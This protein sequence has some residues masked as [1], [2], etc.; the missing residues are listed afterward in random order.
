MYGMATPWLRWCY[1]VCILIKGAD[2]LLETIG[3]VMFFLV[4]QATLTGWILHITAREVAADPDDWAANVLRHAF[5]QMSGGSKFFAGAYLL[6]HGLLK[7]ALV[8]AVFRQ[9]QW[10]FFAAV[11]VLVIF[12]CCEVERF[13]HTHSLGLLA[14]TFL[15]AAIIGLICAENMH[16]ARV[17]RRPGIIPSYSKHTDPTS[18]ARISANDRKMAQ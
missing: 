2:G 3:G 13:F 12:I 1:Y 8:V 11:G 7:V 10:A 14:A 5:A 16:A 18:R 6:G 4:S 9:K 15:D 17:R